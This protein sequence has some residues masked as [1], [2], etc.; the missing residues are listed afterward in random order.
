MPI[1][2]Q[3]G[4]KFFVEKVKKD[5][6]ARP[7]KTGFDVGMEFGLSNVIVNLALRTGLKTIEIK[8]ILMFVGL[9]L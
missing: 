6:I 9:L 1:M 8:I 5:I 2:F 4:V 7:L 3:M